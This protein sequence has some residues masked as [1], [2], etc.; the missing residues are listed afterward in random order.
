MEEE[1]L[2]LAEAIEL[3]RSELARAQGLGKDAAVRF[4]VGPCRGRVRY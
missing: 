4:A 2:E 3:V 1:D